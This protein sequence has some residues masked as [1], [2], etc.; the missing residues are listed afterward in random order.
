MREKQS[1]AIR[2]EIDKNLKSE[3]TAMETERKR[4][5]DEKDKQEDLIKNRLAEELAREK[6]RIEQNA[7]ESFEEKIKFLEKEND[8]RRKENKELRAKEIALLE[9]EKALKNQQEEMELKLKEEILKESEAIETKAREA[10]RQKFEMDKRQLLKQIEDSKK[11]AEEMR[12]KAE[13]GSMQLQG[14]VQ[15]LALEEMLGRKYPFDTIEEVKKGV[16]GADCI[17]TVV[18]KL[19][20]ECGR[21]VYESK[22]T[23]DFQNPWIEKVKQDQIKANADVAVI[24]TETMPK[25]MERFGERDG[26]WICNYR[27][28]ESLSFVLREM[29]IRMHNI[30]SAEENKGDKMEILYN[31]LTSNEFSSKIQRI[32]EVYD[33]M[34]L[35]LNREKRAMNKQWAEREKQIGLVQENFVA[36]FGSIKGIAG[37]ELD[38]AGIL[39]LP[40]SDIE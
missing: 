39:S 17:Q 12:R 18:N 4:L 3:R 1:E 36:L 11:L 8:D 28:V 13:Q 35:Q 14:E 32:V 38:D 7:L 33:N 9:K 6:Q 16:R 26:V 10:E 5:Q 27:E 2:S 20:Q 31:Y 15:E 24:V 34:I 29:I 21:I 19:N 37:N 40:D 25:D 23:K 30:K 22:R